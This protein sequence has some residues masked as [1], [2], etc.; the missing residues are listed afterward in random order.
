MILPTLK[1]NLL[2]DLDRLGLPRSLFEK[3]FKFVS[4]SHAFNLTFRLLDSFRA[5]ND[6]PPFVASKNSV[7][8]QNVA[9]VLNGYQRLWTLIFHWFQSP[10]PD[11]IENKISASLQFVICIRSCCDQGVSSPS[12][13][14]LMYGLLR[15]LEDIFAMDKLYQFSSLQSELSQL[16]DTFTNRI[17]YTRALFHCLRTTIF[18][19]LSGL[20]KMPCRFQTLETQLQVNRPVAVRQTHHSVT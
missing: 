13:I 4:S 5:G 16:L 20:T 18:P 15:I 1:G 12:E 17:K 10:Q 6:N 11:L 19:A 3:R 14:E 9:W 8:R 7:T 2:V